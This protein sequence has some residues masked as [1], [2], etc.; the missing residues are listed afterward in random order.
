ME[1]KIK[2]KFLSLNLKIVKQLNVKDETIVVNRNRFDQVL[3]SIWGCSILNFYK[4]QNITLFTNKNF[5]FTNK[6]YKNFGVRNIKNVSVRI[7]IFR[8]PI[9][10]FFLLITSLLLYLYYSLRGIDYF[11]KYF[12]FKDIKPGILIHESFIKKNK[13]YL[14]KRLFLPMFYFVKIFSTKVLI[15][16][17]EN[18][19]ETNQIKNIIISKKT[20]F[21]LDS[22]LFL[23]AKKKNIKCYYIIHEIILEKNNTPYKEKYTITDQDL[24]KKISQKKIN[25]FVNRR[26]KGLVD[27]DSKYSHN[28]THFFDNKTLKKIFPQN[29]RLTVLF[30]PH[31]FS[32]SCSAQGKFIF[33]DLFDF[34]IKT[35]NQLKQIKDIN[36]LIKMHPYKRFYGENY[37]A[38]KFNNKIKSSNI[39]IISDRYNILSVIKNVD[40]V[41]TARGTI[42]L[43][44]TALGK[45]VLGYKYNR[46]Q[47]C[48]FFIKYFNKKDYFNKLRFKRTNLIIDSKDKELSKKLLY[49]Y[50]LKSYSTEDN[51]LEDIRTKNSKKTKD[52]YLKL[53]KKLKKGEQIIYNSFYYKKLKNTLL[54]EN[55]KKKI[56]KRTPKISSNQLRQKVYKNYLKIYEK[57]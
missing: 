10:S 54:N 22:L 8:K 52:Y 32:D 35:V 26:F 53:Y 9:A 15:N 50:S 28:Q 25:N 17:L 37:V 11:I 21:A 40:A 1:D 48:N 49:L 34:Y 20:Y 31:V 33:R 4:K 2:K 55:I 46:F 57:K 23:I 19:L 3:R 51:L 16:F 7:L 43:E 12:K 38:A 24:K 6:I 13:Y 27:K 29:K 30:C 39:K 14:D 41:V 36:W 42:I 5:Y 45:K 47:K 56:F 18:Y 44:A